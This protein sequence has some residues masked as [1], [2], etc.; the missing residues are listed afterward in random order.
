MD[1]SQAY[2]EVRARFPA[3]AEAADRE[4]IR[5]WGDVTADTTYSWFESLAKALN[6]EVE[7]EVAVQKHIPLLKFFAG[8]L[9]DATDEL[10]DCIDVSFVE[11]LFF[12]ISSKKVEPYWQALPDQLKQFYV[13]FHRCTPLL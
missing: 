4:H 6:H 7:Q 2:A 9:G 13:K 11:N 3:I 12:Q 5:I 8:M 1:L 10:R